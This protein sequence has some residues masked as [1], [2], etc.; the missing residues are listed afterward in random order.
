MLLQDSERLDDLQLGDLKIIQDKNKYNFTSDS[1]LLANFVSTKK[2]D[3][4][5]EIGCGSGVISI[6]VNHKCSPQKI[7]AFEIQSSMADLAKRN[8][9]LN[10]LSDKIEIINAPIQEFEKYIQKATVDVIFSNPPYMKV[11]EQSLINSS[12]EIAISRHEIKLN[13]QDLIKCSSNLLKFGGKLYLVHR[14]ERLSEIF[15]EMHKNQLEPK[16]M[17]FVSPSENKNPNIVLIEAQKGAKSGLKVLP[18]LIVNDKDGNYLYT[19]Q[20][21]YKENKWFTLLLRLLAIWKTSH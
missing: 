2:S 13:L 6:L 19:I 16:R 15:A 14:S 21:L 12:K 17:F 1:A 7:L 20:K 9:T 18:T 10:N 3:K 4:C 11:N 8:I 5:V